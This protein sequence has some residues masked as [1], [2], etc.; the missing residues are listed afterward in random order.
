MAAT[1]WRAWSAARTWRPRWPLIGAWPSGVTAT[2][3]ADFAD[4]IARLADLVGAG[5][6]AIGTDLDGNY[7][8]VLTSYADFA[9]L[10]ELLAGRS[11]SDADIARILGANA[12]DLLRTVTG[13]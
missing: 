2:S 9:T 6:I 3:L 10:P 11:L 12:L 8:P 1:R 13:R 7:R 5:H 4:E